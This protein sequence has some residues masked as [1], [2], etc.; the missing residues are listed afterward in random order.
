MEGQTGGCRVTLDSLS[1]LGLKTSEPKQMGKKGQ[2][3]AV[4]AILDG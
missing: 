2:P 3:V 4:A 1:S